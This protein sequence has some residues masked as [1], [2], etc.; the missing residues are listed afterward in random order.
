MIKTSIAAALGLLAATTLSA[1]A[2]A[3]KVLKV[4]PHADLRVLDGYQTTA[5]ITAMHMASVYDT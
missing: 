1:P 3:Q 4:V 2:H 5:T